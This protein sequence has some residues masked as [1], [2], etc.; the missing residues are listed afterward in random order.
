M[1]R[2]GSFTP[3]QH[4][5]YIKFYKKGIFKSKW[6]QVYFVLYSDSTFKWF[7]EAKD[8][9]PLGSIFLKDMISHICIGKQIDKISSKKPPILE[10]WD[11]MLLIA[12]PENE[13][14]KNVSWFYFESLA[15]MTKWLN[16]IICTLPKR[17]RQLFEST[18]DD[19]GNIS[20][21]RFV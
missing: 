17:H 9:K 11:P 4:N 20:K 2:K 19:Y 13:N 8:E 1:S 10:V 21:F 12:I 18:E 5:G 7:K 6:I 14:A 16:E 15:S 3:I